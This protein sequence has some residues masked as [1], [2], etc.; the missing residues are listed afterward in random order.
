MSHRF[1]L[2]AFVAA[3]AIASTASL[4]A[5]QDAD[6]A[7]PPAASDVASTRVP[8]DADLSADLFYRLLL[9]DVAMQRGDL[10]VAARAYLEAARSTS[11]SRL[12]G[13]ATEVAIA[14][15]DRTLVRDAASL[16]SKLDPEAERPKHVLAALEAN[17]NRG[18]LP[19][20]EANDELR[21]RI[22]HV[23][24]EAALSGPGV[25]D[26]FL[27]LNR[28]FS[29][30]SDRQAVLSLVRDVA[31]PYAKTPEAHYAVAVAAYAVG[32]SDAAAA[33]EARD[34][35]DEALK[36]RPDWERGVMLK[37]EIVNRQSPQEAL[38]GLEAF[39]AAHPD[40]KRVAAAL[41]QRY[42]DQKR[43]A[44]AR[45]VMQRLW[46]RE[47]DSRDLEFGVATIALQMKD[48]AEAQR[49]LE[50]LK[51]AGYGEPGVIDLYLAQVAEETRQWAKAIEHYQAVT[52]GDRAWLAKLRIGAM[53]GKQDQL[54]KAQRYLAGLDAVTKEQKI[55]LTQAQAQLLRDAGDDGGAYRLL[56]KHLAD[57]PDTPD[58]IYDFAM[59]AEKLDK[60]DEAE[61]KLKHLVSLRPDDAQALNALGYTLVDR[62][63]RVDEGL[64]FIRRAHELSPDDPYILDS[65]GWAYYRLGRF[66]DAERFLQKAFAGRADA[67]IAAHLGEVLWRRGEHD[68]ARA[69]WKA[70]LDATPDNRML[71]ETIERFAP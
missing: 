59:V 48:Y 12:A 60:V 56:A 43:F 52:E 64:S 55:Q 68:K 30:Q 51:K 69:V 24:A 45:A 25:G 54:A 11:D 16:W 71:K 31:K 38:A 32:P 6:P 10:V 3:L 46:D 7:P 17:G 63:P 41:A 36:L 37:A 20:T 53:Y 26:V 40:A 18:A 33:K 44:D 35:I 65:L 47:R 39:V 23:L 14:A 34:E 5:Q 49:L 2:R 13:R 4:H 61:A 57:Q 58:L 50:D 62:T 29:G 28:L 42:V 21:A 70:Q 19:N 9:G 1:L 8:H 27:Q 22:E 67:E 66:D 15:R